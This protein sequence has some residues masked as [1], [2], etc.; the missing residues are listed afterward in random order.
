MAIAKRKVVLP[1]IG[2]KIARSQFEFNIYKLLKTKLPRGADLGYE[3]EKLT[4]TLTKDYI[5]DFIV[6]T[7]SGAKIYVE[8]KGLGRAF[9]YDARNKLVAIKE[10]YPDLDLRLVFMADRPISKG[11]KMRT[12]DWALKYGYTFAI[13]TIPDEWFSE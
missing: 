5:P 12:S 11:A 6:T 10:Q 4:Y 13:N 9:D 7:R 3:T 2:H 1:K 8:A